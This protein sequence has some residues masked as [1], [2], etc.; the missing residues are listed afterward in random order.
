MPGE[1]DE[2]A[3]D[4]DQSETEPDLLAADDPRLWVRI[5]WT[6]RE[7]VKRG[8]LPA[9]A[10]LPIMHLRGEWQASRPTV[11]RALQ[12]LET[13]RYVRRYP[14]SVGYVVLRRRGS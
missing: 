13:K 6:L 11:A 9:D 7:R 5:A 10:K 4:E 2:L 12:Y 8:E 3:A 14:G 1:G